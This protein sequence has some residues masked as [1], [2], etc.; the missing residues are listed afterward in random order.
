MADT[1]D[2]ILGLYGIPLN[3]MVTFR[4]QRLYAQL[5]AQ[6]AKILKETAGLT[7]AQ[8]RVLVMIDAFGPVSSNQIVRTIVMDK[9]QLSRVLKG[10]AEQGMIDLVHSES[11]Q[12]SHIISMTQ[13]GRSLF[14]RARPAMTARQ[15]AISET[16]TG[17]E[18]DILI[19]AFDRLDAFALEPL[20]ELV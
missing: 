5:G 4:L 20:E 16:L 3:R 1:S 8:W 7:Q 12:R 18:F 9:G 6:A 13:K 11:D 19:R 15:R 14:E 2:N 17:E 10:M